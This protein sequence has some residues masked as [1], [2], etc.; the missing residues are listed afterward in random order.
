LEVKYVSRS[1]DVKSTDSGKVKVTLWLMVS[2]S[3]CLSV[4]PALGLVTRFFFFK[5][6]ALSLRGALSDE[7]PG[8]PFVSLCHYSLQQ[9]VSIYINYLH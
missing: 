6:S 7:T 5:V 3:V 1:D 4:E 8:L 2:Q 9:S